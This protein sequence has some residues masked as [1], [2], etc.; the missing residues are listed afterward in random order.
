MISR[1]V[2]SRKI[3]LHILFITSPHIHLFNFFQHH[4]IIS[5]DYTIAL[6]PPHKSASHMHGA[7]TRL[8]EVFDPE[9]L[10]E[11]RAVQHLD[12]CL[13]NLSKESFAEVKDNL[14][15]SVFVCNERRVRQL[16]THIIFAV[17]KRYMSIPLYSQ[18]ACDLYTE[19]SDKNALA[20][21]SRAF[22]PIIIPKQ[23]DSR[24]LYFLYFCVGTI[25][26]DEDI[27]NVIEKS[28]DAQPD[29]IS[30]LLTLFCFFA[31]EVES[32]KPKLFRKFMQAVISQSREPLCGSYVRQ[33]AS[34]VTELTAENWKLL[35]ERRKTMKSGDQII[36]SLFCDDLDEFQKVVAQSGKFDWNQPINESIFSPPHMFSKTLIQ[37][38]ARCGSVKCFRYLL[39]SGADRRGTVDS[40]IIGG[41]NEIVRVLHQEKGDFSRALRCAANNH[42][43]EIFSWLQAT[44]FPIL[45][46]GHEDNDIDAMFGAAES[47][48]LKL[49]LD[50]IERGMNVNM[51]NHEKESVLSASITIPTDG[52]RLLVSSQKVNKHTKN[53]EGMTP[54]LQA[55]TR[56]VFDAVEYFVGHE[57][58]DA[59]LQENLIHTAAFLGDVE[60]MGLLLKMENVDLSSENRAG[61]CFLFIKPHSK[62]LPKTVTLRLSRCFSNSQELF[63]HSM[64][65]FLETRTS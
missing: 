51:M 18:L 57:V 45:Q 52:F 38:A 53:N 49:M 31:P 17:S 63:H 3:E 19:R 42:R 2:H 9:P 30:E 50:L 22:F 48:N 55:V 64:N 13:M 37:F 33:F 58:A 47:C 20:L 59:R 1:D 35:K 40:A 43:N 61:V 4:T 21:L 56:G 41:S 6:K 23:V 25:F 32:Y 27:V 46:E 16:A 7:S 34:E 36:D 26:T 15:G 24:T 39:L 54:F 11:A 29:N 65:G 28:L 10:R 44:M 8:D 60:I 62:L 14:L 12:E 5:I